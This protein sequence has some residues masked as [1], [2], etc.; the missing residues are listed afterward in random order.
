MK[1]KESSTYFTPRFEIELK[2]LIANNPYESLTSE[3]LIK[4]NTELQNFSTVEFEWKEYKQFSINFETIRFPKAEDLKGQR[5]D[6]KFVSYK[7][8]LITHSFQF[9]D[10]KIIVAKHLVVI[11]KN[12]FGNFIII[13]LIFGIANRNL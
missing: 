5:A 3:K 8:G 11:L 13:V 1:F 2:T 7:V 9:N 10:K 6:T 4:L 12:N